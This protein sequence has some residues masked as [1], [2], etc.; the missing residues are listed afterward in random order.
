LD[1]QKKIDD[2]L[3]KNAHLRSLIE[4]ARKQAPKRLETSKQKKQVQTKKDDSQ[5]SSEESV[6]S[7]M[8]AFA[9]GKLTYK[10]QN[11]WTLDSAADIHIC[12]DVSHFKYE[13]TAGEEDTLFGG[14]ETYQIHAYGTVD[15]TVQTPNDTGK[16]TLLNV[17]LVPGFLTNLVA[18]R[19]FTEKGVHWDT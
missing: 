15:L 4:I 3:L 9:A 12:N 16:I 5:P 14:K 18:L 6:L 1:I 13:K 2:K 10:L 8:G 19:R 7:T 17:A 11:Y